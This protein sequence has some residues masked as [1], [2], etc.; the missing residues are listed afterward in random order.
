M[1]RKVKSIYGVV[2]RLYCYTTVRRIRVAVS[3]IV[4]IDAWLECRAFPAGGLLLINR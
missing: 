3:F 2:W 1:R 4:A